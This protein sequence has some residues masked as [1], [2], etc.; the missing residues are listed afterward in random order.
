MAA[1]R[2]SNTKPELALRRALHRRGLR[3]RVDHRLDLAS[4]AV[5]PDIVFTKR[6]IAVYVDGCYWHCCPEHATYPVDNKEF[7]AVK[8]AKNV[9]RD[10]RDTMRLQA[11]G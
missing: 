11:A 7:W 1:V 2:R 3:Y 10:R 6:K 4:G 8:L 5:R 9:E